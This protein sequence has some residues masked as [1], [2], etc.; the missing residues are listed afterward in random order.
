MAAKEYS[1]DDN[2]Y[3][4]VA[5]AKAIEVQRDKDMEEG[6]RQMQEKRE[7]EQAL[8]RSQR[9]AELEAQQVSAKKE[10]ERRE[11]EQNDAIERK[12][13]ADMARGAKE[14]A[15]REERARRASG[16][17]EAKRDADMNEGAILQRNANAV[18]ERSERRESQRIEAK[19]DADMTSGGN[20]ILSSP[21]RLKAIGNVNE[22][23]DKFRGESVGP[24]IEKARKE[25]KQ[26][27]Y[28]ASPFGRLSMGAKGIFAE[29]KATGTKH[30]KQSWNDQFLQPMNPYH[31]EKNPTGI[32]R[33]QQD[34]VNKPTRT[35]AY[36]A[37]TGLLSLGSFA[38]PSPLI[39]TAKPKAAPKKKGKAKSKT[40]RRAAPRRNMLDDELSFF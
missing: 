28:D 21:S 39:I 15:A 13:D 32:K 29:V 8:V 24:K 40:I 12:R 25:Y 26:K 5:S 31:K 38:S 10:R 23:F 20:A 17:I 16:R 6:A 3:K 1:Q 2:D 22:A 33:M 18:R 36:R 9:E 11:R 7:Y 30:V 27:E 14:S 35:R 4:D 37:P 34:Y 19:R